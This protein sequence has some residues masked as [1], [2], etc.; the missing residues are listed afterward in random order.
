MSKFNWQQSSLGRKDF[1]ISWDEYFL[2]MAVLVAERSTCRRHSVGAVIVRNK[3][4]LTTGYNGSP[5]GVKD[6]FEL[7]CLRD[8]LNIFS[9]ENQ[10][11][12]RATHA[13]QNAI[14]Q[15]GLHG[16]SVEGATLYTTHS[17]CMVC[18]KMIVNA[19]IKKVVCFS[20]YPDENSL[21]LLK[22]AGIEFV[23]LEKPSHEIKSWG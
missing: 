23:K 22:A 18:T 14:I 1:R 7:G 19:G 2:K 20:S 15:A 13:E 3:R 8:E 17:P 21:E 12:C 16:V 10:E 4:V 5:K 6:C 11:L 9:G